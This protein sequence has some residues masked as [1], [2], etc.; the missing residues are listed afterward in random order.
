M[1]GNKSAGSDGI[2]RRG[3]NPCDGPRG[4]AWLLGVL[5]VPLLPNLDVGV[6]AEGRFGHLLHVGVPFLV[7]AAL[8]DPLR[9]LVVRVVGDGG[10]VVLQ[11]VGVLGI[12]AH[13]DRDDVLDAVDAVARL[14][15]GL[16]GGGDLVSIGG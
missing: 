15:D 7:D 6:E 11:G 16:V 10:V 8:L 3:T 9:D 4:I 2:H 1:L 13:V 5:V 12:R 14:A